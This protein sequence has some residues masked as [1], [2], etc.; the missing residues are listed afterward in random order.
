MGIDEEVKTEILAVLKE[1][2]INNVSAMAGHYTVA[3]IAQ[4]VLLDYGNQR[5]D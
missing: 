2:I 4:E 5:M 3:E 1:T